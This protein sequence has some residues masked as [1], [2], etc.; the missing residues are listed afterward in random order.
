MNDNTK[1]ILVVDDD[2][3]FLRTVEGIL[4]GGGYLATG[5]NS[6]EECL[7][8]CKLLEPDLIL[9]DIRM[10]GLDGL[11]VCQFLKNN[12]ETADIPVIFITADT[13]MD[14]LAHAFE[15]G[16]VDYVRKPVHHLELLARVKAVFDHRR[17]NQELVNKENLKAILEMAGKVCHELN[18]PLQVMMVVCHEFNTMTA[19]MDDDFGELVT[20]LSNQIE[21]SRKI[22][23][24]LSKIT[25]NE[26]CEYSSKKLK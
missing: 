23:A 6:G 1:H 22:M 11:E 4:S 14:T 24:K 20:I 17:L 19:D 26:T 10:P 13:D 12:S 5:L 21:R 15:V 9:L 3:V 8:K 2:P 18:Q 7:E 16:G 25:K